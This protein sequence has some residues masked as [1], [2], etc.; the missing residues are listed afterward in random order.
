MTE[1]HAPISLALVNDYPVVTQGIARMLENVDRLKVVE[2]AS[3]ENPS[4]VVDLV[5][6]DAFAAH[7]RGEHDVVRLL[8]DERNR[9]L[10]VYTW[11]VSEAQ[12]QQALDLGIDGYLSKEL[13]ARELADALIRI[14]EGERVVEPKPVP[15]NIEIADWPGRGA[16]LSPREAEVVA[17]ITQGATNDEI[18]RTCYLSINSVKS[19]IRS[20]YRKMGVERRSQAVLWG[21]Q[22]GMQ[23][24]ATTTECTP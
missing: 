24:K 16:G 9:K 19:Y 14:H 22:N 1:L 6:Y 3:G 23:P 21:V 15:E 17:L 10:V 8:D 13:G 18:A 5:L 2:R 11:H 7:G 20:A 4:H 12:V